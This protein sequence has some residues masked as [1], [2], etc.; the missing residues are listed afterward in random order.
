MNESFKC[1]KCESTFGAQDALNNHVNAKHF[2]S[3][4]QSFGDKFKK[5][6]KYFVAL[7]IVIGVVWLVYNWAANAPKIGPVGSTHIHQDVKIYLDGQQLDLSQ[8]KYQVRAPQVHVED[9]DGDVIHVHATG[10]P[11]GMFFDSLGMKLTTNCFETDDG[12]NYC[13][14]KSD[15]GK[16]LKFYVNGQKSLNGEFEKY[17][18]RDVDKILI[19]YGS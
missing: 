2:E 14:E 19:S 10:V 1:Q 9:G 15:G 13:N 18:P 12:T 17:I 6:L 5:P 16:T 7:I 11:I 3:P 4:K 8:Q